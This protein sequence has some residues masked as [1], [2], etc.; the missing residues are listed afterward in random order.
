VTITTNEIADK[1]TEPTFVILPFNYMYG[2]Y[3]F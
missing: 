2:V 1:P 3:W